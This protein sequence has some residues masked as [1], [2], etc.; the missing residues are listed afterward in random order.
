[1]PRINPPRGRVVKTTT[2]PS[3]DRTGARR[4]FTLIELLV[5]VAIIALLI[6]IL[7][8][9][10]SRAK[11]QAREV[12]CRSNLRQLAI[13]FLT[14]ATEN[15][16]IL[17]CST[18]DI[19]G[20]NWPPY[21]EGKTLCWLGSWYGWGHKDHI[22]IDG[23][24]F[25]YVGRQPDI[26]RCPSD[27]IGLRERGAVAGLPAWEDMPFYSYTSPM[28]LTGAPLEMIGDCHWK[29]KWER[30]W[31][32]ETGWETSLGRSQAW[33]LVEEDPTNKL[34]EAPD[35]AW[36]NDDQVAKR[37]HKKSGSIAFIDGSAG[38]LRFEA[39]RHPF[40]AWRLYYETKDDRWVSA[41][42]FGLYA[43]YLRDAPNVKTSS[44]T[45]H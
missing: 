11:D 2:S 35:G 1:M 19:V 12:V 22:P 5:V 39:E 36:T 8:P 43:G 13:G 20:Q 41:G 34:H 3:L 15:K 25:P 26:Y 4:A 14:Y 29:E 10:L 16:D 18:M 21:Q 27:Q 7:L 23:T 6:S 32:Y 38:T 31:R 40:D 24:I 17:P 42:P 30:G 28:V 37:H 45:G 33:L 44:S 9:A